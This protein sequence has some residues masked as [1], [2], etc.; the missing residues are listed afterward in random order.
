MVIPAYPRAAFVCTNRFGFKGF[1]HKKRTKALLKWP[2]VVRWSLS[3]NKNQTTNDRTRKW[4]ID[5]FSEQT[6]TRAAFDWFS[7][8]Q[9]FSS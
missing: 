1:V 4:Q 3:A 9:A 7:E 5:R 8:H 2:P 6:Q